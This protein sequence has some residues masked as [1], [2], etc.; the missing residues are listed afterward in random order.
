VSNACLIKKF[1]M[2]KCTIDE[3]R[4]VHSRDL[5]LECTTPYTSANGGDYA[6]MLELFMVVDFPNG[7]NIDDGKCNFFSVFW[8][9]FFTNYQFYFFVILLQLYFK[10]RVVQT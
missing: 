10:Y 4:H 7:Q 8:I 5:I 2:N 3:V 9:F 1:D 6:H